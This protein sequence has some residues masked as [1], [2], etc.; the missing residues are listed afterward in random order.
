MRK[1]TSTPSITLII[2]TTC[3]QQICTT[4]VCQEGTLMPTTDLQWIRMMKREYGLD[5]GYPWEP[6]SL[7]RLYAWTS[8]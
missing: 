2:C 4:E 8:D 7:W 6:A 3:I 5:E 1:T